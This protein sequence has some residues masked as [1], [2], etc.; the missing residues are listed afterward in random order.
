MNL[1]PWEK[2]FETYG[3]RMV[4][5]LFGFV[6]GIIYLI[7]GFWKTVVF[8]MFVGLGYLWGYRLDRREDLEK[9]VSAILSDKWIRK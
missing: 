8:M 1:I 2:L 9:V 5:T 6:F 7:V 4:G 3:G